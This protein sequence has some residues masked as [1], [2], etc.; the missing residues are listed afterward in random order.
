MG[1]AIMLYDIIMTVM[2]QTLLLTMK[3]Q[4]AS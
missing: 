3:K 2:P 1:G 4:L